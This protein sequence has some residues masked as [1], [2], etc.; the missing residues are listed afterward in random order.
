MRAGRGAVF[1]YSPLGSSLFKKMAAQKLFERI[2]ASSLKY[3][4]HLYHMYSKYHLKM[5]CFVKTT[6]IEEILPRYML[7]SQCHIFS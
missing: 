4:L 6:K 7:E 2:Y 5:I 1:L 3:R